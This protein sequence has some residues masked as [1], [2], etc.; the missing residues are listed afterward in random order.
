M[1]LL[2]PRGTSGGARRQAEAVL[3]ARLGDAGDGVST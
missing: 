2:A 1:R 3:A